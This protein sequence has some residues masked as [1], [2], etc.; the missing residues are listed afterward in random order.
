MRKGSRSHTIG[1]LTSSAN[2]LGPRLHT[3]MITFRHIFYKVTVYKTCSKQLN[4]LTVCSAGK[5][6]LNCSYCCC[7]N[8]QPLAPASSQPQPLYILTVCIVYMSSSPSPSPSASAP[9]ERLGWEPASGN[10][11]PPS[12]TRP[13]FFYQTYSNNIPKERIYKH[14]V[15][16]A[17][18]KKLC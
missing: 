5:V 3:C 8:N 6:K 17:I 14:L 13:N 12:P 15:P 11:K 16:I 4:Q 10:L 18:P 9:A 1:K 2:L 7:W